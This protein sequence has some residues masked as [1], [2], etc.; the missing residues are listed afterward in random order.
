MRPM[1]KQISEEVIK[2]ILA[3]RKI[4]TVSNPVNAGKLWLEI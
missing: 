3:Q 4:L 1:P 2:Y